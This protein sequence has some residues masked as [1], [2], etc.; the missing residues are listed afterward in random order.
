MRKWILKTHHEHG[1]SPLCASSGRRY[2]WLCPVLCLLRAHPAGLLGLS[3]SSFQLTLCP[4]SREGIAK[5]HRRKTWI[6]IFCLYSLMLFTS[7]TETQASVSPTNPKS[8]RYIRKYAQYWQSQRGAFHGRSGM[9]NPWKAEISIRWNSSAACDCLGSTSFPVSLPTPCWKTTLALASSKSPLTENPL[10]VWS[11]TDFYQS[12][13]IVTYEAV[14]HSP[15]PW[16]N[17][18][19]WKSKTILTRNR[20]LIHWN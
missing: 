8:S 2:S 19:T 4:S 6:F 1:T 11:Y 5:G 17:W 14:L 16:L 15:S 20:Y 18:S 7:S 12:I 10:T 9:R 13:L 3:S